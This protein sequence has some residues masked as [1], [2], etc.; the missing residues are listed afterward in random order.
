MIVPLRPARPSSNHEL[1]HAGPIETSPAFLLLLLLL[2]RANIYRKLWPMKPS[3]RVEPSR[4]EPSRQS[5]QSLHAAGQ[6][7]IILA[8]FFFLLLLHLLPFLLYYYFYLSSSVFVYQFFT[9][10]TDHLTSKS[11]SLA[12]FCLGLA[13]IDGRHITTGFTLFLCQRDEKGQSRSTF[14]VAANSYARETNLGFDQDPSLL[15][16]I[17]ECPGQKNYCQLGNID[18]TI[19]FLI[20][21]KKEKKKEKMF[22]FSFFIEKEES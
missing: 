19:H 12:C 18:Q 10:S 2:I 14:F 7:L 16:K 21:M 4:A 3:S 22:F 13:I 6:C 8:L 17:F 9:A 20:L 1:G 15:I 5:V 11:Q